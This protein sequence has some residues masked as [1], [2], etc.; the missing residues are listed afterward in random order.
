M[1]DFVKVDLKGQEF[2]FTALDFGQLQDLAAQFETLKGL[3]GG[4]PNAEQRDAI[5][6]ICTASLQGKHP[7][8]TPD[9]VM[10]LL[11]LG[12][13]GIALKAVAGVS[14]LED[15]SQGNA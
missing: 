15:S 5:V 2:T 8:T 11:T 1:S 3:D 12:N 10:R 14:G 13:I 9:A 6:A 7:G 4:M